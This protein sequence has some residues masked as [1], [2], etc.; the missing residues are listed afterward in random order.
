MRL[1]EQNMQMP[2]EKHKMCGSD[3]FQD[4]SINQKAEKLTGKSDWKVGETQQQS[5]ENSVDINTEN[6]KINNGAGSAVSIQKNADIY[7]TAY[8]KG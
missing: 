1:S 7:K 3:W 2:Q 8:K 6:G 5:N 4:E